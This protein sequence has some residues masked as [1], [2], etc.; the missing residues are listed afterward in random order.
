MKARHAAIALTL[1]LLVSAAS[2][3]G[4]EPHVRES[5]LMG[6]RA[7]VTIYGMRAARA[8]SAAAAG[9]RE[10]HRIESIL[11]TWRADSDVSRLNAAPGGEPVSVPPEVI[12]VLG[13]AYAFS[14]FTGGAF[15]VTAR[16]LVLLWGFQGGEAVLPSDEA[17]EEARRLVGWRKISFAEGD[18]AV[19]L[20]GGATVDLAGI[21]KGYAV[22]RCAEVL[23]A[24][25]VRRALVDLGGNM[26]AIGSPPGRDA[27]TIGIRDPESEQAMIGR[28]SIRDEAVSTSGNYENYVVIGG[29]RYGHII[30]PRTGRPVEHVLGVTVVAATATAADALST[31]MF[32]LGPEAA[33]AVVDIDPSVRA[34]FALPGGCFEFVGKFEGR[35]VMEPPAEERHND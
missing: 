30:D 1:G 34:V 35:L 28:L 5:Y 29:R 11:S 14:E 22:D 24:H 32:V 13:Q 27:W 2:C 8:D 16:P 15:D 7:S 6:T 4:G 33:H 10:M 12:D 9:L 18:T 21:G 26:Y 20:S 31:G 17:I 25:G 19:I 23:R 3:G